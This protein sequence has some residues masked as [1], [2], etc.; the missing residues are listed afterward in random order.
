M[1]VTVTDGL[2][3]FGT[4]QTAEVPSTPGNANDATPKAPLGCLYRV[5]GKVYRYVK[6]DNG[7]AV[8][9]AV[10][11]AVHWSALDPPNSIFT[12]TSDQSAGLGANLVAG[13][14]G[15][16]VTDLYY[17]WIQVGG[18]ATC[19]LD[20]TALVGDP[21]AG[22]VA[23]CKCAYSST[24]LKLKLTAAATSPAAVV[25]GVLIA[26]ANYTAG[27]GSVLLQNLEW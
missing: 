9:A 4:N 21:V 20:F 26:A 19:L 14:L 25:Y 1:T 22:S 7:S 13:I 11:G 3:L 10:G 5:G 2:F 6:F 18:V 17:T 8:A 27:T 12:V 15:C 24:D 16:V 23:G